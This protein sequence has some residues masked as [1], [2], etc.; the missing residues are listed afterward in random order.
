MLIMLKNKKLFFLFVFSFFSLI[1]LIQEAKAA[2]F[3]PNFII[4]DEE[5]LDSSAM[6]L[7]DIQTFLEARG[8]Y[9]AHYT[10]KNAYGVYKRASEIIYDA[11]V[12]NYDCD[13][14]TNADN[15]SATQKEKL[16]THITLNPKVLLVLLQ[17]EQSLIEDPSP[18]QRQLDWATGYGCPDS[19]GCNPRW[20]GFGKQVNSA[21]LQF[22]D[23]MRNPQNYTYKAG[24]TYTVTN[25]GR[26]PM[27][28]TPVNQATAALYNYTPHVYNGNYNFY[29]LWIRYFTFNYPNGT[30]LQA[31]GEPGVWLIQNGKRRPFLTR[32]ALTSR[33]DIK[34]IIQVNK[35]ELEKYP[36]GKPLK[37][38]QY[39]LIRSPRGT[40]FLI[41][42]D[43]RRGFA[44]AEAFRKI[45]YN[46]EEIIDASW[47]DINAY[48]EGPPIT[49]TSTYPTGALLQDKTTGG[50]YYVSEGTKAPLWD[51]VL[52]RTKF[53]GRAIIPESPEKL[54]RFKTVAPAIFNDGELLKGETSP[55]VY[56]IDNHRKRPFISGE[57]F[58][59]LG[60]KWENIITVPQKILDLYPDGEPIS[61][62]YTEEEEISATTPRNL[63]T[64][65]PDSIGTSTPESA[66]TSTTKNSTTTDQNLAEEIEEILNP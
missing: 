27:V 35:S 4:S 38:P 45:G 57:I 39:S 9:L 54:A 20:K 56:V 65:T 41:V 52:L 55:A 23:Y 21:A 1:C 53:R 33:F 51:A 64:S 44:S 49:A 28:I 36:I 48:E 43:K 30:L 26:P 59:K 16:C 46:P 63:A 58:E 15:L 19:G 29:K 34:K 32:G 25:T 13:G 61:E 7:D 24:H 6:D 62:I 66:A 31:K 17:K 3:N 8:S 47:D 50:I 5:M 11:A 2:N 14:V 60:Y 12:N 22:F 40:V 42:D 37:F 18:S 10:T